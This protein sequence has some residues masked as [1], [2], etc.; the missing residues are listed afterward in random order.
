MEGER[1]VGIDL[2]KRTYEA[3]AIVRDGSLERWHGKTDGAGR[4][5]LAARL[6]KGDVVGVEAGSTA[7]HIARGLQ[8]V[9]GIHVDVPQWK[10]SSEYTPN[11]PGTSVAILGVYIITP[12]LLHPIP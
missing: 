9:N 6:R 3:C 10:R 1:F 7:F 5:R 2:G 12:L 8:T 11:L 4:E